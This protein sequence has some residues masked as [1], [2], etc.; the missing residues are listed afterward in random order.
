[1]KRSLHQ[2][3]PAQLTSFDEDL[4]LIHL[5]GYWGSTAKSNRSRNAIFLLM[6]IFLMIPLILSLVDLI[7]DENYVRAS[8]AAGELMTFFMDVFSIMTIV[9]RKRQIE[10]VLDKLH[11]MFENMMEEDDP[12]SRDIYNK[13][14]AISKKISVTMRQIMGY[15]TLLYCGA[16]LSYSIYCVIF[17]NYAPVPFPTGFEV[18]FFYINIHS[19]VWAYVLYMSVIIPVTWITTVSVGIKDTLFIN[20]FNHCI[21]NFDILKHKIDQLNT[22]SESEVS[23]HLNNYVDFHNESFECVRILEDSIN[24][25]LLVHYLGSISILCLKMFVF[26]EVQLDGFMVVRLFII[27]TYAA[28]E[29][30]VFAWLGGRLTY[31]STQVAEAIYSADWYDR[32]VYVQKTLMMILTRGQKSS[33]VM[34]G[35]FFQANRKGLKRAMNSVYSYFLFI[36]HVYNRIGG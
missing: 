24:M 13:T 21:I 23:W 31:A 12:I 10:L 35:K 16:P 34:V 22:I 32:P 7:G 14:E 4:K 20:I 15:V 19:N 3:R 2:S 8:R 6:S 26:T 25:D 30:A 36:R 29:V 5:F 28:W 33:G 18:N 9:Y 17:T 1:M 27:F 11:V